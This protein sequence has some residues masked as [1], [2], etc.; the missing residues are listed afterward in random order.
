MK[1]PKL[2]PW[3]PHSIKPVRKGVYQADFATCRVSDPIPWY[4]YFDG[5]EW[6]WMCLNVED[7]VNDYRHNSTHRH[8]R[9]EWRG[10]V[11]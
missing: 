8:V 3:F 1:N 9:L 10:I 7:A 11:K 6:G 2:T 5:A 4:A